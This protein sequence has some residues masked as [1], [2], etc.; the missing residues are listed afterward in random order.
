MSFY[1]AAVCLEDVWMI[2]GTDISS[3]QCDPSWCLNS[4]LA[5]SS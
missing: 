1:K 5:Q 2:R 4:S 3:H